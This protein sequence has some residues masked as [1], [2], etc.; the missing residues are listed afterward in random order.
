MEWDRLNLVKSERWCG[1]A[2]ANMYLCTGHGLSFSERQVLLKD[3]YT[4]QLQYGHATGGVCS[5][6][7]TW[8]CLWVCLDRSDSGN[9]VLNGRGRRELGGRRHH[10]CFCSTAPGHISLW[11][12][13]K[14]SL[15]PM[16]SAGPFH[17]AGLYLF[18]RLVFNTGK[19]DWVVLAWSSSLTG[20]VWSGLL[21][22]DTC[23]LVRGKRTL[24][25]NTVPTSR[26]PAFLSKIMVLGKSVESVFVP[27]GTD[28]D[29]D[30]AISIQSVFILKLSGRHY[31]WN[32]AD[33]KFFYD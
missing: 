15:F 5:M 2:L 16:W 8:E 6:R 26:T 33:W 18:L 7:L 14:M 1:C 28:P 4:Q 17:T 21:V 24:P 19:K 10:F 23:Q 31:I 32:Q 12:K 22:L 13:L 3:N 29:K 27:T 9:A 20:L 25:T 11:I 30:W